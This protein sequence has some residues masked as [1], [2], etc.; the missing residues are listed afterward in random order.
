MDVEQ[1]KQVVESIKTLNININDAT[2]QKLADTVIPIVKMFLIR[3]YVEMGMSFI[4]SLAVI[5]GLYKVVSLI[6]KNR[7]NGGTNNY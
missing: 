6:V 1:I 7:K 4:V 3:S 5:Y 2:T